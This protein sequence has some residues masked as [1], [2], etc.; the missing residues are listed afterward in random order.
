MKILM[1]KRG[2]GDL[3]CEELIGAV[4]FKYV[5][6]V[7]LRRAN[8]MIERSYWVISDMVFCEVDDLSGLQWLRRAWAVN[9]QYVEVSREEVERVLRSPIE[10][11]S[12]VLRVGEDYVVPR[13]VFAGATVRVVRVTHSRITGIFI[14]GGWKGVPIELPVDNMGD[15]LAY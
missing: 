9:D 13:G 14:D 3:L 11:P 5:K 2:K 10:A 1:A 8:K 12:R 4:P 7:R 15:D 6:R